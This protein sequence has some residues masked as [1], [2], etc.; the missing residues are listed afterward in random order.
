MSHLCLWRFSLFSFSYLLFQVA[1]PCALQKSVGLAS[2]PCF[3]IAL[4]LWRIRFGYLCRIVTFRRF[5][6]SSVGGVSVWMDIAPS[7]FTDLRRLSRRCFIIEDVL[8]AAWNSSLRS[9]NAKVKIVELKLCTKAN[10]RSVWPACYRLFF[11]VSQKPTCS[12]RI[13]SVSIWA[14]LTIFLWA[15]HQR[16]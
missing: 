11:I 10:N 8:S 14:W 1:I 15:V 12:A 4:R 5:L 2:W 7:V 9:S 6:I 3:R 13:Y 16:Q